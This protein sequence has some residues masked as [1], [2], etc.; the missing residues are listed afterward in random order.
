MDDT[1][2]RRLST[3]P[4]RITTEESQATCQR[5]LAALRRATADGD[6]YGRLFLVGGFVRD[7]VRRGDGPRTDGGAS[8]SDLDIVLEGDACALAQYL[9]DRGVAAYPPVVYPRFGTAMVI[10]EGHDVELVTARVESYAHDSRKPESVQPGT[11]AQDALRRDFTINTLLEN[12][13][14]GEILD[15]TG[16]G[17]IDLRDE[18]IRTPTDPAT[19]FIDDPL[20]ML[21]AIRFAARFGYRID[22]VTWNAVVAGAHRLQI[23]SRE[24]IR[25]EFNKALLSPRPM[26]ALTLLH[27]S[28]LLAEFIPEL[29]EMTGVAQN[30]FHAY[31]VWE[32]TLRAVQNLTPSASLVVRLAVLYHDIGKP[33]TKSVDEDGSIH[34]YRHEDVGAELARVIMTRLKYS[35][36]EIDA[37]SLLVAEHMR[38]GEYHSGWTDAAVRRFIRDS[39]THRED[40]FAIH[41]ADVSALADDNRDMSRAV[42]L[43]SRIEEIQSRQDIL[44]LTSPLGGDAIMALLNLKPGRKVKEAKDYLTQEVVEGRL[45][46][47]DIAGA[48]AL[49]KHRM[50]EKNNS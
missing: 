15:P 12:L 50:G 19:T 37:V 36:A 23:V 22:E 3:D 32:H 34:F 4:L 29:L 42:D 48:E 41:A 30:A 28:G 2:P 14:T 33:R 1:G 5:A 16:R 26:L 39:G 25:D 17:L 49:L 11:L 45:D 6:Y 7:K 31:D 13:H 43:R 38:I 24:R 9:F 18:I 35:N 46:Q 21:R 47:N 27:E 44:A 40:L 10:V 8:K 20:R